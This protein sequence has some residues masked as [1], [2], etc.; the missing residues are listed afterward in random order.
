MGELVAYGA[1]IQ[2]CAA[3]TG[4]PLGTVAGRWDAR[5]GVLLEPVV[6]D[7]EVLEKVAIW[8]RFVLGLLESGPPA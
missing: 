6:R 1:A 3:L 4:E 5:R 2:A 8:R 7:D